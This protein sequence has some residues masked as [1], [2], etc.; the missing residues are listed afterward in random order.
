MN[1][2][3]L[4]F[5]ETCVVCRHVLFL[6]QC[7]CACSPLQY[8]CPEHTSHM[9]C[10]DERLPGRRVAYTRFS[11]G[12]LQ[13]LYRSDQPRGIPRATQALTVPPSPLFKA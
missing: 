4:R 9:H 7:A 5:R 12:E 1:T 13:G 2:V 8:Y 6:I 10:C 11:F 3:H